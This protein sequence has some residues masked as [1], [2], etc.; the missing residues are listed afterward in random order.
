M[1]AARDIENA[2]EPARGD[3]VQLS[4]VDRAEL[5]EQRDSALWAWVV[6][7]ERVT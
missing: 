6:V 4:T 3:V 2:I 1:G 5:E 7:F